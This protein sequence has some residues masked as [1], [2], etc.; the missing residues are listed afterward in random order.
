MDHGDS[1]MMSDSDMTTLDSATGTAAARLFLT[2]MTMH[3]KGA[4]A[5]AE[6][7]ITGGKNADAIDLAKKIIAAQK[8]EIQVMK[9]LLAST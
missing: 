8:G 1:G 7:E 4:I 9:D 3:H 5:M 2:G 6:T